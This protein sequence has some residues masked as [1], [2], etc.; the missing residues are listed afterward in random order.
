[1]R[2]ADVRGIDVPVDVE[3]ADVAVALLAH[4][5][6][7]PAQGQQVRRAIERTPSSASSRSPA[8]TLAA[9]G[10]SRASSIVSS[11]HQ[12]HRSLLGA[13]SAAARRERYSEMRRP[14]RRATAT[15]APQNSRNNRLI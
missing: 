14:Y 7:Q 3:V 9:I 2:H 4:V 6:G 8:S 12:S 1:M 11:R 15:A 13:A 5:V 10:S